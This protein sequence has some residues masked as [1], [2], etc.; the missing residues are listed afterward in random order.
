MP[1]ATIPYVD[2]ESISLYMDFLNKFNFNWSDIVV[3][4][5]IDNCSGRFYRL[6]SNTTPSASL[7]VY[8]SN[9]TFTQLVLPNTPLPSFIGTLIYEYGQR[10]PAPPTMPS[11]QP[12][13]VPAPT[14]APAPNPNDFINEQAVK[15][16]LFR[17]VSPASSSSSS[18][19]DGNW[20][21]LF[22]D[23]IRAARIY[24]NI[25]CRDV[26]RS[27]RRG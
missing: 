22:D 18:S 6:A 13:L 23:V 10:Q 7:W 27:S 9:Q 21:Q 11:N 4:E 25:A 17:P 8:Q 12:N 14:P 26:T 3:K 1:Y 19:N 5:M 16:N 15:A 2:L 24:D 20:D